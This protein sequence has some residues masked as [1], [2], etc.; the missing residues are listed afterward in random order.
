M[1]HAGQELP[2]IGLLE[3]SQTSKFPKIGQIP[4]SAL[5][6]ALLCT[7]LRMKGV[8]GGGGIVSWEVRSQGRRWLIGACVW[9]FALSQPTYIS[10]S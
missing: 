3:R 5:L 1:R 10:C 6:I 8:D 4:L 7:T 2:L 9:C